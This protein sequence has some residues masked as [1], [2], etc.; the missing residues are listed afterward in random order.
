MELDTPYVHLCIRNKILVGTYK[1]NQR[2]SLATAKEIVRTRKAFTHGFSMP[3]LIISQGLVTIDRPARKFF[4]S[5]EGT[6]G[7]KACAV[8]VNSIFSSF[9]GNFFL[10]VN[11]TAMPVKIFSNASRA[12]KWLQQ[13]VE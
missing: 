2:I 3:A 7:L 8:V 12:E 6:A 4:S 10:A 5:K 13:F 9:L 1:R 11:K